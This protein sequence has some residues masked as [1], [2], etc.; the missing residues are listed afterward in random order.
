MARAAIFLSH[1]D[2][3]ALLVAATILSGGV[4][5]FWLH[6]WGRQARKMAVI[7]PRTNDLPVEEIDDQKILFERRIFRD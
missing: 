3:G 1:D 7:A 4:A 5:A 6:G 2:F